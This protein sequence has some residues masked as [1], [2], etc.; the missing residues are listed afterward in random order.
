MDEF[1]SLLKILTFLEWFF[2]I[3]SLFVMLIM[4]MVAKK[5]KEDLFKRIIL[6]KTKETTSE[7]K[8]R[9][10]KAS[11]TL[12]IAR[13]NLLISTAFLTITFFS[14]WYLLHTKYI[15]SLVRPDFFLLCILVF[16][17]IP[18]VVL[19]YEYFVKKVLERLEEFK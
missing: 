9:I 16:I 17:P 15:N 14:L 8:E 10:L 3:L 19:L 12:R 13:I 18:F 5:A 6:W 11:I 4:L 7:S 2:C 1:M